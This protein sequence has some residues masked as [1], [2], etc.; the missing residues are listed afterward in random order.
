MALEI[1][2]YGDADAVT[3]QVYGK[4][5]GRSTVTLTASS[6]NAGTKPSGASFARLTAGE[7]CIVSNN[8]DTGATNG[9]Y[10]LAGAVIDMECPTT[11]E[12][13][14]QTA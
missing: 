13:K 5:L 1:T 4:Q 9:Q 14:A 10:L 8:G 3:G 2:Y 11:G 6:A 7:N 12:F